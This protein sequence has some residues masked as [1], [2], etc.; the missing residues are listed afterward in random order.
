VAFRTGLPHIKFTDWGQGATKLLHKGDRIGRP[1]CG[2]GTLGTS[3]FVFDIIVVAVQVG[4]RGGDVGPERKCLPA[5]E[6]GSPRAL[7]KRPTMVEKNL[8]SRGRVAI[9]E[10]GKLHRFV[11]QHGIDSS[12]GTTCVKSWL[13]LESSSAGGPEGSTDPKNKGDRV[14][15]AAGS[16][17]TRGGRASRRKRKWRGISTKG[18]GVRGKRVARKGAR[19][20]R[21]RRVPRLVKRRRSAANVGGQ[22][23]SKARRTQQIRSQIAQK[24]RGQQKTMCVPQ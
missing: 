14:S 1:G 11:I 21:G 9:R 15:N 5:A 8:G 16:V 10:G 24:R 4:R 18:T 2:G 20:E 6:D 23:G 17:H 13:V 12:S 19:E 7:M 22:E 3:G